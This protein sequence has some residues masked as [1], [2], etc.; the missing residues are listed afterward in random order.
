MVIRVGPDAVLLRLLLL[1]L[2]LR[3]LR[4]LLL[5][6]LLLMAENWAKSAGA[7]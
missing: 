7:G 5:L 3:L 4:L 6:L 1:L 2:L